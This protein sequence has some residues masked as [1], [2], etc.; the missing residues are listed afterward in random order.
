MFYTEI[1]GD[2]N[3]VWVPTQTLIPL[4]E[5]GT[6]P[7]T[8]YFI[9]ATSFLFLF[10]KV[11]VMFSLSFSLKSLSSISAISLRF[12]RNLS[13]WILKYHFLLKISRINN[14]RI[15]YVYDPLTFTKF[16]GISLFQN[17]GPIYFFIFW[18][19]RI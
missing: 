4:R 6:S 18:N 10:S 14:I 3:F 15:K 8:H 1:E 11:I 9:I 16:F 17:F 13:L 12:V 7:F 2:C 5:K 19:M